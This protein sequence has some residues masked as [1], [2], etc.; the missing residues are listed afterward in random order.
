[1]QEVCTVSSIAL[2]LASR[3]YISVFGEM[4]I[5]AFVVVIVVFM[6]IVV[7]MIK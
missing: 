4:V 1:M 3:R 7:S 5:L 6:A 2:M